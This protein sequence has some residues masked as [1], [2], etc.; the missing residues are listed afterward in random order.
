MKKAQRTV[1]LILVVLLLTAIGFARGGQ[2]DEKDAPETLIKAARFL[3]EKPLD[4]QA[5][6]VRAWAIKWVIAT[7]KVSVT[8]CSLL[9]SGIDKKYK[10]SGEV[11]G[12]YTIAMAAF[13]L[14][15]PDKA[16]DE[17]AAQ[18]A[19][20]ESALTSY[21]AMV[22][23]QPK[24]RNAFLDDLSSK[25]NAGLLAKYVGENNCKDKK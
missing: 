24:A 10:Y 23:E 17:D 21:E 25:H 16:K 2:K 20:I 14:T 13:K 3:E 5:K 6:D 22:K 4:K 19:G 7:D 11:F 12:Q 18:L 1:S 8:V 15:N 9:I